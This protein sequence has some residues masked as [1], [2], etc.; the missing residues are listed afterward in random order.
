MSSNLLTKSFSMALLVSSLLI[1]TL[2]PVMAFSS[3][4]PADNTALCQ[5]GGGTLQFAPPDDNTAPRQGSGGASRAV[6]DG[7]QHREYGQLD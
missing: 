7:S 3:T 1:T 5:G 2:T 4:S 6:D